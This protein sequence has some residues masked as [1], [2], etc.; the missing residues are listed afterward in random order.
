VGSCLFCTQILSE[1]D[2]NRDK[3]KERDKDQEKGK[4]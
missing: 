3:D 2:K 1:S 4:K